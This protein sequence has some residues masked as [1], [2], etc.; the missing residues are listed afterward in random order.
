MSTEA[1]R[2]RHLEK[3]MKRL[4]KIVSEIKEQ[5][6]ILPKRI[7]PFN[8]SLLTDLDKQVIKI[9]LESQEELVS[10]AKIA[11]KLKLN[12]TKT[13]RSLKRIAKITEK[14][15]GYP[16][17][18]FEPTFKKWSLNRTDYEIMED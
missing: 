15:Y 9:L 3:R 11:E 16:L 13:W 7:N 18:T 2:L 4:E 17:V 6:G 10:N 8:S 1:S 12:R 5:I 14:G